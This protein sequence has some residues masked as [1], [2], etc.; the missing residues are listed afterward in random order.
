MTKAE[1][2]TKVVKKKEERLKP[3]QLEFIKNYMNNGSETFG[4]ALQSAIKAGYS[5]K[6]ARQIVSRDLDW[7]LEIVRHNSMLMK[8]EEVLDDMLNM[9]VVNRRLTSSGDE[10]VMTDPSLVRNKADVAKFVA[11]RI[12]K[13]TWSERKELTAAD[14]KDLFNDEDQNKIE[15]ALSDHFERGEE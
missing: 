4:N 7:M 13:K 9:E 5:D 14:G 2:K 11:S 1:D 8:A 3:Q 12:G 10:I 15:E 6:Y